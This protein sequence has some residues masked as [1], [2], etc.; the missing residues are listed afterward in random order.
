MVLRGGGGDRRFFLVQ[1]VNGEHWDHPK[2]HAEGDE[3]PRE[4]ARREIREEGG[5]EVD[6][7]GDF[8][9]E[10]S[11]TLPDGRPKKVVYYLARMRSEAAPAGPGDG[12]ESPEVPGNPDSPESSG[13]PGGPDEILGRAWLSFDEAMRRITYPSGREVLDAARRRLECGAAVSETAS[14]YGDF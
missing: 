9:H 13:G 6:F 14:E 8:S 5:L 7:I 1:H 2:G 11:W 3:G 10:V 12:P 4:T